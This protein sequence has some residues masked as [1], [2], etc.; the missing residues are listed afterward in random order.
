[1]MIHGGYSISNKREEAGWQQRNK[2]TSP[3][4]MK[5]GL[6]EGRTNSGHN[7]VGH[8]DSD[9][10]NTSVTSFTSC[11]SDSSTIRA[12]RST[13][14]KFDSLCQSLDINHMQEEPLLD[15]GWGSDGDDEESVDFLVG[16]GAGDVFDD[17]EEFV[18]RGEAA[19][20]LE[21]ALAPP[22]TPIDHNRSLN[23]TSSYD[24]FSKIL[25][26]D[27]EA[28]SF[29]NKFYSDE[30]E[31]KKQWIRKRTLSAHSAGSLSSISLGD[32]FA[33]QEEERSKTTKASRKSRGSSET[34]SSLATSTKTKSHPTIAGACFFSVP[35]SMLRGPHARC[36]DFLEHQYSNWTPR[37]WQHPDEEESHYV[38]ERKR[39]WVHPREEDKHCMFLQM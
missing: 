31:L 35:A 33:S 17:D 28:K 5:R 16:E 38:F 36:W 22:T 34:S 10:D 7:Y 6:Y 21:E 25:S 8:N 20:L 24:E 1:M 32:D 13:I 26:N 23:S 14:R 4:V 30:E 11:D 19:S 15:F 2:H 12:M 27:P 3:P 37:W 29:G 18:L 9:D 39:W